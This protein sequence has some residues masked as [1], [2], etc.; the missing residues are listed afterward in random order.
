MNAHSPA[1]LERIELYRIR[2]SVAVDG[3]LAL[4]GL[5][6]GLDTTAI[7]IEA[8]MRDRAGLPAF[9][10]ELDAPPELRNPDPWPYCPHPGSCPECTTA[11][12]AGLPREQQRP[13]WVARLFTAIAAYI[14][15]LT[16]ALIRGRR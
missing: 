15:D 16:A 3:L 12:A 8:T 5:D 11:L 4:R 10:H 2:T 6:G 13:S 7:A 1:D 14:D 9:I